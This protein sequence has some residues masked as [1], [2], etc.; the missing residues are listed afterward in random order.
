M[1]M[2][3]AQL[4]R[5]SAPLLSAAAIFILTLLALSSLNALFSQNTQAIGLPAQIHRACAP[6]VRVPWSVR[7]R[8]S[9]RE[10]LRVQ[11]RARVGLGSEGGKL[12]I[13][14]EDGVEEDSKAFSPNPPPL[15]VYIPRFQT[16]GKCR[17]VS[18][19]R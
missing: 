4:R 6:V 12:L 3:L 2:Y 7:A 9:R 10:G 17:C 11:G 5:S 13:P 14:G 8:R 18:V 1:A 19:W 16:P 15:H